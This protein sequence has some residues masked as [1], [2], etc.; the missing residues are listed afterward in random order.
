MFPVL[1][2]QAAEAAAEVSETDGSWLTAARQ[3]LVDWYTSLANLIA[4]PSAR[5]V[6]AAVLGTFGLWLLM[7]GRRT[8]FAR[9]LGAITGGLAAACLLSLVPPVMFTFT[10][11]LFALLGSLTIAA[12][13]GTV[14]SKSPIYNAVWFAITLLG[15]G[16]LLLL[17]G[18]QFL[19]IATVAVYAGAIVVTFLFVLMLAQPEGYT[20][21][22]RISWGRTAEWMGCA[23]GAISACLLVWALLPTPA[24]GV[25]AEGNPV[26]VEDHVAVLGAQ[27]FTRHLISVEIAGLLL[28]AALV[29]CVAIAGATN[30]R[31]IAGQVESALAIDR[32]TGGD[33]RHE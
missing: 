3:N 21:Y 32:Q 15:V 29:G 14:T 12:A 11:V 17:N 22:D 1:F 28:F 31:G 9:V 2:A 4:L 7:P 33:I 20:R 24:V 8:A 30:R 5:L 27:L 19:G 10:S 13:I 6:A 18:A 26:L 25:P 16:G 23:A